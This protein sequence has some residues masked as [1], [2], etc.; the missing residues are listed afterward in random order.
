MDMNLDEIFQLFGTQVSRAE[1]GILAARNSGNGQLLC[2]NSRQ[3]FKSLLMQGLMKW[4]GS[5]DPKVFLGQALDGLMSSVQL[6]SEINMNQ[7]PG[8]ELP[9]EKGGIVA[10]LLGREFL[11]SFEESAVDPVRQLDIDISRA[12]LSDSS[13]GPQISVNDSVLTQ[14]AGAVAARTYAVYADILQGRGGADLVAEADDLFVKRRKDAFYCGGDHTE[15]GGK[16]NLIVVDYRLAA[17]LK[18]VGYKDDS[19][20]QWW[21]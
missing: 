10:S 17:I 5:N 6:L 4:R 21:W 14:K 1:K 2:L 13:S 9:L 20:H 16:D 19:I 8:R 18:R 15:G 7:Q 3:M 11:S 12:L